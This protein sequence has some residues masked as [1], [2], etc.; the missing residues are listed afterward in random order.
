VKRKEK[1]KIEKKKVH[2]PKLALAC[3]FKLLRIICGST[4][5]IRNEKKNRTKKRKG[6]NN[7]LHTTP[8]HCEPLIAFLWRCLPVGGLF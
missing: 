3:R 2:T 5:A 6:P 4:R 7:V 1:E 8:W